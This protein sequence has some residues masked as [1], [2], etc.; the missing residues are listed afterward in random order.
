MVDF[1]GKCREIYHDHGCYGKQNLIGHTP[2]S[3]PQFRI[4]NCEWFGVLRMFRECV[5]TFLQGNLKLEKLWK[6]K[7][8]QK[9]TNKNRWS[10]SNGDGF[11]LLK[12]SEIV[13][14]HGTTLFQYKHSILVI[15]SE[16]HSWVQTLQTLWDIDVNPKLWK[17]FPVVF[18]A[19]L[20]AHLSG[21]PGCCAKTMDALITEKS[22]VS[23][24]DS[25]CF[26]LVKRNMTGWMDIE[27]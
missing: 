21:M 12:N 27:P 13:Q 3:T 23:T 16:I 18:S 24:V 9:S 22:S 25:G 15:W 11:K 8:L 1:Y 4:I 19:I 20:Q 7:G 2:W 6:L 10:P 17:W 5:G 14:V 26:T